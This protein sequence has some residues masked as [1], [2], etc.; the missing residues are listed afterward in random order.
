[1]YSM[2]EVNKSA[3]ATNIRTARCRSRYHHQCCIARV[4]PYI[5]VGKV[6]ACWREERNNFGFKR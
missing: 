2:D 3:A 5:G 6:H 4:L 1:M